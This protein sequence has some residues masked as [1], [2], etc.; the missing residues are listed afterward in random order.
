MIQK[1]DFCLNLYWVCMVQMKNWVGIEGGKVK[2]KWFLCGNERE[3]VS[4]VLWEC[5]AY[6]IIIVLELHSYMKEFQKLLENNY[7]WNVYLCLNV[8]SSA[9]NCGYVVNSGI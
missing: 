9:H 5:S 2:R 8:S 3:N 1:V 7:E 4:H 6:G